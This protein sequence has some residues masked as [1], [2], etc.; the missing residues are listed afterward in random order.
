MLDIILK[1][2]L[3]HSYLES[4]R[5]TLRNERK[6][7]IHGLGGS[8]SAFIASAL[9]LNLNMKPERSILAVFPDD[10]KADAFRG[11]V[12]DII[13]TE[14]VTFFP[15]RDT[16]PYEQVDSHVEIRSQRVETLDL[17]ERGWRG[18]VVAPVSA[19]HDP[20]T[21]PGRINLVSFE[22]KKGERLQFDDFIRS[23]VEKGFKRQNTVDSAGQIAVRGG[24]VDIFP[25][26]C[27]MPYRIEFWGDEVE[28]IRTFSIA[29]QRSLEHIDGFRIIPS[30]EFVS[31]TGINATDNNRIKIILSYI[32]IFDLFHLCH[33]YNLL[34]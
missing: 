11:D 26:E 17:L 9:L 13:G 21:P 5:E 18:I 3:H 29:T 1:S 6:V 28:S 27:E 32:L 14:K 22:V 25:F 34:K 2:F 4:L 20:T 12:E 24:I 16:N 10:E 15:E 7:S 31:E 19:I 8:S 33:F 23:L 30:D